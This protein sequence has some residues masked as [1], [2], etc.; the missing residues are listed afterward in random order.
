[1]VALDELGGA[2]RTALIRDRLAEAARDD[3]VAVIARRAGGNPLFIEE[4]ATCVRELGDSVIPPT[5][6]DVLLARVDSLSKAAKTTLQY[7]A[8]AGPVFRSPILEE[9]LGPRVSRHLQELADEGLVTRADFVSA[10]VDEGELAFRH[11]VLQEAM[12]ESLTA[13]A[14]RQ[15]HARIGR[16]LALRLDAGREEPPAA[17]ARHL[18]LGGEHERAAVVWLRA[19]HVAV[20]ADDAAAARAAFERVLELDAASTGSAALMRREAARA[21]LAGLAS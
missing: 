19:G 8:V 4:L 11:G 18:E 3:T 5:V 6:R 1:V 12:Y 10:E 20:A 21:A 14:R 17:V 9:I 15:T 13:A 16:I 7:A 2:G